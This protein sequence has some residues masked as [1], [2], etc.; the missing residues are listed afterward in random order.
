MRDGGGGQ[1]EE[2]QGG[3]PMENPLAATW[4]PPAHLGGQLVLVLVDTSSSAGPATVPTSLH[5]AATL[6]PSLV[7]VPA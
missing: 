6:P 1:P 3:F 4:A 5:P 2:A 7:T